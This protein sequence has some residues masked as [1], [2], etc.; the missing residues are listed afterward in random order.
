[1]SYALPLLATNVCHAVAVLATM[2]WHR[3]CHGV[4]HLFLGRGL[5]T[6]LRSVLGIIECLSTV[7][8]S[9]SLTLRTVCN[10]AAGHVLL[11]VLLEMTLGV[12][13]IYTHSDAVRALRL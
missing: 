13:H 2:Q 11:G 5:H 8:R 6:A 10:G 4:G 12:S 3:C 1:M 7:F 9:V